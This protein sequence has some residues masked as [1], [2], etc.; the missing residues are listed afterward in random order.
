[1]SDDIYAGIYIYD[2]SKTKNFTKNNKTLVGSLQ[3]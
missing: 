3:L 2:L 1:M